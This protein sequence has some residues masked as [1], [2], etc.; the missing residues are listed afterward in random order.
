MSLI[1][2]FPVAVHWFSSEITKRWWNAS[3][4]QNISNLIMVFS[5]SQ[6]LWQ[7]MGTQIFSIKRKQADF[8]P[9]WFACRINNDNAGWSIT[10]PRG[11]CGRVSNYLRC[12]VCE[13]SYWI[14]I[15]VLISCVPPML[16][17]PYELLMKKS[18]G[19]VNCHHDQ[20]RLK[21]GR[22]GGDVIKDKFLCSQIWSLI[23]MFV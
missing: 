20:M 21:E 22:G 10:P 23:R 13:T 9:P 14:L 7:S 1:I 17:W 6:H 18:A 5:S 2:R 15:W 8:D 12:I 3:A 19:F 4:D 11:P 16:W